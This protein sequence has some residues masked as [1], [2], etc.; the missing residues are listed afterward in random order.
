MASKHKALIANHHQPN[1]LPWQKTR[2][3]Y[4]HTLRRQ[5]FCHALLS[6]DAAV[7][8]K[9]HKHFMVEEFIVQG[10]CN[11]SMFQRFLLNVY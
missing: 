9:K 6:A 1:K 3:I 5:L 10:V 4:T 8:R 7:S 11:S 2:C